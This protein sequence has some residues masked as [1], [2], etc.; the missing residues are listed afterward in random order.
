MVL[1]ESNPLSKA[2]AL[3]ASDITDQ[4]IVGY[5]KHARPILHAALWSGF[6]QIGAHP[7]IVCEIIDKSTLLQFVAH[8]LGIALA[9]A[10]VQNIAPPGVTFVPFDPC[11]TPIELYVA[12]RKSG[13]SDTLNRFLGIIRSAPD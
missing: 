1:S 8:G 7:T 11:T 3:S 4:P 13:N 10:W 6:C 5:P 2:A 12:Y 9:P